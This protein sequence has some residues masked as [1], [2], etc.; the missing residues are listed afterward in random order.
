MTPWTVWMGAWIA[1]T[2]YTIAA[3]SEAADWW[4]PIDV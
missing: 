3:I 2:C 1:A 4:A